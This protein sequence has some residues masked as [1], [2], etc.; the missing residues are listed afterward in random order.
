MHSRLLD[1][2]VQLLEAGN[3]DDAQRLLLAVLRQDPGNETTWFTYVRTLTSL[4]ERIQALRDFLGIDPANRRAQ[5]ELWMLWEQ[6]CRAAVAEQRIRF[7]PRRSLYA[8]LALLVVL[9]LVIGGVYLR[10]EVLDH[11]ANRYATLLDEHTHL[12]QEHDALSLEHSTL[13]VELDNLW[14]DY[15]ASIK[16]QNVLVEQ[17]NRLQGEYEGMS[18]QHDQLQR[19]HNSLLAA[20]TALLNEHQGLEKDHTT[21]ATQYDWLNTNALSPP[22]ISVKGRV[23][24]IAFLRTDG[25]VQR[26]EVPFENLEYSLQMGIRKRQGSFPERAPQVNLNNTFNGDTY[27]FWDYR[28]FVDPGPFERVMGLLYA[29]SASDYDFIY[30]TW[31]I[32]SQL[33]SYSPDI[34]DTPRYPMETFLAGGGDCEDTSILFASMIKAAPVDWKVKLV[35]MDSDNPLEPQDVDHLMVE[36]NTGTQSYLVETTSDHDMLPFRNV[37]G[38]YFE[39]D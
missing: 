38:W 21:L 20:H 18:A 19:E 26:W 2:A 36:V 16:E 31:N 12:M 14:L 7:R 1:K 3:Q 24:Y 28:A 15:D 34:G 4:D 6:K 32:V 27:T 13:R 17:H 37:W 5:E 29:E 8:A 39:I 10:Q 25:S 23:V 35:Y 30:E 33:M 22:Y 9:A 11:W